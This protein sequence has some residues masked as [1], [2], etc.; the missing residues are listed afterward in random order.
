MSLS[1]KIRLWGLAALVVLAGT[2]AIIN[3]GADTEPANNS[4]QETNH[5]DPNSFEGWCDS[6]NNSNVSCPGQDK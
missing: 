1:L 5:H 2:A 4:T 6:I 3:E